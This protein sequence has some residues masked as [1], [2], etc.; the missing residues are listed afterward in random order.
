MSRLFYWLMLVLSVLLLAVGLTDL[1][2]AK[3][4][5]LL[6]WAVVAA[7]GVWTL[8]FKRPAAK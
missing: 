4:A 2:S 8:F 7:A 6:L 3:P 5:A 1:D